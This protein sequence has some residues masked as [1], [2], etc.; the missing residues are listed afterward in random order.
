[1]FTSPLKFCIWPEGYRL[2]VLYVFA[3]LETICMYV[4]MYLFLCFFIFSVSEN[5]VFGG[6]CEDARVRHLVSRNWNDK[7]RCA[8]MKVLG[9][10]PGFSARTV[11]AQNCWPIL[12]SMVPC[13][14]ITG[15]VLPKEIRGSLN[16][17]NQYSLCYVYFLVESSVLSWHNVASLDACLIKTNQV[18][19]IYTVVLI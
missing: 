1:M 4:W 10:K 17:D 7:N 8:A 3:S 19:K 16:S 11:S 9:T 2:V 18:A 6:V 12:P 14:L 5:F 13:L 15:G